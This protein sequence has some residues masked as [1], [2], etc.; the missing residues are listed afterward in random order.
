EQYVDSS[1]RPMHLFTAFMAAAIVAKYQ[2]VVQDQIIQ[3]LRG[4]AYV[5]VLGGAALSVP[6]L[7]LTANEERYGGYGRVHCAWWNAW[8]ETLYEYL[9]DLI[10]DTWCSVK[11]YCCTWKEATGA[12][13]RRVYAA[14]RAI[15]MGVVATLGV[16]NLMNLLFECVEG[17]LEG[18]APR[19]VLRNALKSVRRDARRRKRREAASLQRL[20]DDG[21]EGLPECVEPEMASASQKVRRR[22]SAKSAIA[23]EL[24]EAENLV[25]KTLT[26]TLVE[27]D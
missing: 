23:A 25:A 26:Q 5:G 3:Q 2:E 20:R 10:A 9:P 27:D 11:L 24:R 1:L 4:W 17:Q 12:T 8:R 7:V 21:G 16:F 18:T 19:M 13:L 6:T 14:L 15:G 22:K